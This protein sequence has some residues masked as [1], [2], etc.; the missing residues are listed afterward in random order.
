MKFIVDESTG[1][2]AANFLKKQ[3]HDTVYVGSDDKGIEDKEI[4][5]KAVE[6]E[7]I[8]ITND[9]DFGRLAIKEKRNTEG[10]LL[11]RLQIETPKNKIKTIK[12]ILDNHKEKIS[13]KL[14]IAKEN[15]IKT[16]KIQN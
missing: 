8:I 6:Q 16:R 9:K 12:N 15:Q 3:G 4:M 10:I 5:K 2:G 7:R 14:V 1:L 13:D 11:L